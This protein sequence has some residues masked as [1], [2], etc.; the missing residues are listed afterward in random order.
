MKRMNTS[1]ALARPGRVA[2]MLLVILG[3]TGAATVGS[4]AQDAPSTSFE[5][6]VGVRPATAS[7]SEHPQGIRLSVQLSFSSNTTRL[8]VRGPKGLRIN[9]KSFKRCPFLRLAK[10]PELCPSGSRVGVASFEGVSGT[11][12]NGR[13]PNSRTNPTGETKTPALLLSFEGPAGRPLTLPF[14]IRPRRPGGPGFS[15]EMAA[16]PPSPSPTTFTLRIVLERKAK[17]T[18]DGVVH[19]VEA[20]GRCSGSWLFEATDTLSNGDELRATDRVACRRAR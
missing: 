2:L 8:T 11:V 19:Y 15:N 3:G 12:W 18:R 20:P 1:R 9:F 13:M 17:R 5:L 7:T 16:G 6:Q 14:E 4:R 10:G